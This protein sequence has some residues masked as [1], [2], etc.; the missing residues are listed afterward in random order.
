MYHMFDRLAH[1]FQVNLV[2]DNRH[3]D[4]KNYHEFFKMCTSYM[5]NILPTLE[6]HIV[7]LKIIVRMIGLLP[8]TKTNFD[9]F[10]EY[11]NYF[12]TQVL[13]YIRPQFNNLFGSVNEPEQVLFKSGLATLL[14][15]ELL[16]STDHNSNDN[17][18]IFLCQISDV[19]QR[20]II[21]HEIL[22]QLYEFNEPIYANSTWTDLFT[23]VDPNMIKLQDIY[24]FDSFETYIMFIT[25]VSP[26]YPDSNHFYSKITKQLKDL[27]YF[28]NLR[29]KD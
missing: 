21:A 8:I 22:L 7:T 25:K 29:S 19:K 4:K 15:I 14:C 26:V 20:Q 5:D 16:Y 1:Q 6:T 18:L 2:E 24:I 28:K 9:R 27:I 13:Q 12:A 3:F 17:K 23:I 10:N 11:A